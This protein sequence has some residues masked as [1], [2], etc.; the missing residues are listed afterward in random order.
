MGHAT[1]VTTTD[2]YGRYRRSGGVSKA[3]EQAID[4]LPKLM[5]S[6]VERVTRSS[7][8]A[9]RSYGAAGSPT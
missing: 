4:L 9:C 5:P 2:H 8:T 1:D 3:L 6:E 7:E